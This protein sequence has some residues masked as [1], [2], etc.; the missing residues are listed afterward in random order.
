MHGFVREDDE[1]LF[2]CCKEKRVQGATVSRPMEKSA[3]T[4]VVNVT[5]F[6]VSDIPSHD[7]SCAYLE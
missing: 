3:V 5:F 7:F 6:C 4:K 1:A 2:I